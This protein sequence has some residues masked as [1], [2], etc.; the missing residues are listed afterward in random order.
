MQSNNIYCTVNVKKQPCYDDRLQ[1]C[2]HEECQRTPTTR[3]L[4]LASKITLSSIHRASTTYVTYGAANKNGDGWEVKW[5]CM[6]RSLTA[7]TRLDDDS[8]KSSVGWL[9]WRV[10]ITPCFKGMGWS[11]IVRYAELNGC[12]E[13][14]CDMMVKNC[15]S[16]MIIFINRLCSW[17]VLWALLQ[18]VILLWFQS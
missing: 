7:Q 17:M 1:M 11:L 6:R 4:T 13:S 15:D 5:K 12:N 14:K 2:G 16:S 8:G 3:L 18:V 9:P 10:V